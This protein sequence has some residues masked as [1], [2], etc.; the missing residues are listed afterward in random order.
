MLIDKNDVTKFVSIKSVFLNKI[1]FTPT[2]GTLSI[3]FADG[4]VYDY[5]NVPKV[6]YDDLLSSVSPGVILNKH[7]KGKFP[8]KQI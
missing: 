4:D 8:F 2:V 3:E 7:I 1:A 5:D 6:I